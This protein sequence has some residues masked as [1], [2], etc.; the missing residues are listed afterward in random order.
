MT[1]QMLTSD[2]EI[3]ARSSHEHVVFVILILLNELVNSNIKCLDISIS[4]YEHVI[5]TY[6]FRAC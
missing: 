4:S 5:Q 1:D 6:V 3:D 2:V